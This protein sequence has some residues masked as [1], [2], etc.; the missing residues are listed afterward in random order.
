MRECVRERE[1]ERAHASERESERE[2]V[3]GKKK[4]MNASEWEVEGRREKIPTQRMRIHSGSLRDGPAA[5]G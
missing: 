1:S 3:T 4:I 2:T 5:Q